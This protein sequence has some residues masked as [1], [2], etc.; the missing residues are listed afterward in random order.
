[1]PAK[2][3]SVF[4]AAVPRAVA[5]GSARERHKRNADNH[6]PPWRTPG[7]VIPESS[8]ARYPGSSCG[9]GYVAAGSRLA[10]APLGRDDNGWC[11]KLGGL[12]ECDCVRMRYKGHCSLSSNG[13]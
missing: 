6:C 9:G 7:F 1:S 12:V 10:A 2:T 13:S 4:A 11:R 3:A 8:A 5:T